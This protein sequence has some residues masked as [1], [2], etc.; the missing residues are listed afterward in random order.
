MAGQVQVQVQVQQ[1]QADKLWKWGQGQ[2]RHR[3]VR[4]RDSSLQHPGQSRVP[5]G[6]ELD[7]KCASVRACRK[8]DPS[9]A[10][11]SN[12]FPRQ[13]PKWCR[14]TSLR[15]EPALDLGSH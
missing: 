12:A 7:K 6:Q 9:L 4:S 1:V 2:R 8:R 13:P 14:S 10:R 5:P 15:R 3:M 11:P